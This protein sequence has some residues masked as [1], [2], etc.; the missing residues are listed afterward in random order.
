MH[1]YTKLP[2]LVDGKAGNTTQTQIPAAFVV[3]DMIAPDLEPVFCRK[4][5]KASGLGNGF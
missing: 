1:V 3:M 2:W 5:R 4:G